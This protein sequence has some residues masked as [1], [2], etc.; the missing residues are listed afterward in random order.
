MNIK[1]IVTG[2][3]SKLLKQIGYVYNKR[4]VDFIIHSKYFI[5]G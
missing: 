3:V 2:S 4:A 5:T 1:V